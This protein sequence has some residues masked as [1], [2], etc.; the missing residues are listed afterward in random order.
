MQYW[1]VP[2]TGAIVALS[3][4]PG[5]RIDFDLAARRP[6]IPAVPGLTIP[7]RP[8]HVVASG[9]GDVSIVYREWRF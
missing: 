4:P 2:D 7:A 8:P 1:A 9:T 3:L 5:A 6:G